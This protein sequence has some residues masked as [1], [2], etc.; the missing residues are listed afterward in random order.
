METLIFHTT[1]GTLNPETLSEARAM[2]NAF[3]TDG[4]Q[5]GIEVARSLGDLSHNVY[6]PAEGK[7]ELFGAKPGELL[8]FDYWADPSGMEQ[9]FSNPLAQEA[10]DRLFSSR[11]ESEWMPA[12]AA[13]TFQV[14]AKASTP[15]RFVGIARA[16]VPVCGRCYRETVEAR[17]DEPPASAR[18]YF[19]R[20]LCPSRKRRGDQTSVERAPQ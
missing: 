20:S 10:G 6:T 19:A 3:V 2:H 11:E 9:F 4:P 16:P 7:D 1:R 14:P 18:T 12:R 17:L 5:P 13:F 15:A 8:L